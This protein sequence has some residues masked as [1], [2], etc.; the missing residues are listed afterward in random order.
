M[1]EDEQE[2]KAQLADAVVRGRRIDQLLAHETIKAVR[3]G[4]PG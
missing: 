2:Q 4:Q 3:N 1:T